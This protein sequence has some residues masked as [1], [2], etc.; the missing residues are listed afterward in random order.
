M[1][2]HRGDGYVRLARA[3]IASAQREGDTEFFES[4][5]YQLLLDFISNAED[6]PQGVSCGVPNETVTVTRWQKQFN[7]YRN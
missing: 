2:H 7:G 1:Q 4:E 3:I 6:L 5:W